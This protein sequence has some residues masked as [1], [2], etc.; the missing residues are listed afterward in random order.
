MSNLIL[1]HPCLEMITRLE[2]CIIQLCMSVL[3]ITHP[4]NGLLCLSLGIGLGLL[5]T[6]KY[7]IGWRFWWVGVFTFIFS[8][9]GHLPFNTVLLNPW[10][11]ETIEQI[12]Q[13]WQIPFTA[14]VLGLSAGL[15]EEFSRYAV[16][17]WWIKDARTWSQGLLFGAGHG[18][19][20]AILIGALSL[21][22]Y[23]QLVALRGAD[24]SALF[25]ADQV[26]LVQEQVSM[27]WTLPWYDS[28]L[29]AVER[30]FALPLHLASALLVLQAFTR[31]QFR[32]VWLAVGLHTLVN[33]LAVYLAQVATV[34]IAE[35]AIGILAGLEILIILRLRS[36]MP[37]APAPI[38]NPTTRWP[39]VQI[40]PVPETPETLEDTRY[41]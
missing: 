6:L 25:P 27:Y 1:P 15:F 13:A 35:L 31:Q 9:I 18:G 24:L 39:A 2:C 12:P 36:T 4:L 16:Y 3:T 29:G 34:Y 40:G 10:M 8:Q 37:A 19:F 28:L 11:A 32:W 20:E 5:I 41:Q 21:Y 17:R 26:S 22:T 33:T 7:K 38:E 30:L 23:A 14:L